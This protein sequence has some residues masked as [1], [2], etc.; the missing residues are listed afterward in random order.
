MTDDILLP[1]VRRAR[2][3]SEDD[4]ERLVTILQDTLYNVA[5]RM[6]WHPEDAKEATQE[7][8]IRVVT[9]LGQFEGKSGFYTW[10]YSIAANHLRDCR[11]SRLEERAVNHDAF[12]S[13][14]LDGLQEPDESLRKSPE[15]PRMLEEVRIGCTLAMLLCLDRAHRLAYI[16][17]E[18]FELDHSEASKALKISPEA[19]RKQLSRARRKVEDFTRKVCGLVDSSNSCHCTKKITCAISRGR[20]A[21][22]G[23]LFAGQVDKSQFVKVQEKINQSQEELKVITLYRKHPRFHSPEDFGKL[24]A[25]M[26]SGK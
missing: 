17:G 14:L 18:I 16:L 13:D 26:F 4:L 23:L 5:L 10:V 15:Y 22:G 2:E 3:G 8:L 21:P 25:R 9:H 24:I 1:L 6:L 20:V 7:I 19:F 11:K 12:E